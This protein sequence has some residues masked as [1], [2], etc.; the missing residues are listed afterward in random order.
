M[1]YVM[2]CIVNGA[3]MKQMNGNRGKLAAQAG[4]AYLHAY[5]DAYNRFTIDAVKYMS[6]GKATKVCLVVD[7]VDQLDK[8]QRAYIDKC[9]NSMVTDAG[10]TVFNGVPTVTCLG[11]GPILRD[12]VGEDIKALKVLI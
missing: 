2:Y 3:A 1:S 4:H 10:K 9:G 6:E 5:I 7:N 11:V 12:E 8:I